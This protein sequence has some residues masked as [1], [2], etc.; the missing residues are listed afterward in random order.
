M[1]NK[2]F[3]QTLFEMVKNSLDEELENQERLMSSVFET[4]QKLVDPEDGILSATSS[5]KSDMAIVVR[6]ED[7]EKIPSARKAVK[8]AVKKLNVSVRDRIIPKYDPSIEVTEVSYDDGSGRV[9][10]VFKYDI[11]SREGL[12]LEHVMALILTGKVTE[13]LKNR[14][15]LPPDAKKEEIKTKLKNEYMDVLNVAFK[16]KSMLEAKIG[17]IKKAASEGSRNLKAD[18]VLQAQNG[19]SYG[20]SIK[21]VQEEGREVRFTY[22]KNIGYGDE[23]EETL[24]KNPSGKPWWLVGRQIFAKKLGR[25]YSSD[26]ENLETPSWM[27]KA[28]ESKPDVYKESME[29][30][31]KQLREVFVSNLRKMKLKDLVEMVNE[32]HLGSK[33]EREKY[34]TLFVLSSDVDGIKLKESGSEK[35]DVEQ[36]KAEGLNKEDIVK[37]DGAKIIIEIPGMSPLTIHG[38][39]FHSNMLSSNRE[40]LKIKTR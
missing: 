22:N 10:I 26:S 21:L 24:V 28:K 8:L 23:E 18:L 36:I 25:S 38:L 5:N 40:D 12:I 37:M 32:A 14:L 3:K 39:K 17:K 2:Q 7:K 16:G 33:E 1:K 9:Y 13:E 31:Y 35:P 15:G 11:G 19:K 4:L 6:C 27:E 30:V 29:E 34:E 20:L